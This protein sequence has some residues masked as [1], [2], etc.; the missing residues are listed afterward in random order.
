ML[1]QG[2]QNIKRQLDEVKSQSRKEHSS[3]EPLR[4][5]V[6]KLTRENND[7]HFEIIHMKE[8]VDSSE[9]KWESSLRSLEDQKKDLRFVLDQKDAKMSQLNRDNENL[10]IRVEEL[11]SKLYL[12]SKAGDFDSAPK[13]YQDEL[14][15]SSHNRIRTAGLTQRW[16]SRGARGQWKKSSETWKT[17]G[18]T[19]TSSWPSRSEMPTCE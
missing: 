19:I 3:V 18:K 11:L 15:A 6:E 13:E 2:F 7:L 1:T 16:R 14:F 4:R 17:T 12:P 5:E 10:R 8:R 9:I